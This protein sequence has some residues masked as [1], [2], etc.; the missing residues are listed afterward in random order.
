MAKGLENMGDLGPSDLMRRGISAIEGMEPSIRQQL[1]LDELQKLGPQS[2]A[3]GLVL[4][5]VTAVLKEDKV[6]PQKD[7]SRG[8]W[9]LYNLLSLPT[10]RPLSKQWARGKEAVVNFSGSGTKEK[11]VKLGYALVGLNDLPREVDKATV[12][13]DDLVAR[14][15][16]QHYSMSGKG[17][18]ERCD[19]GGLA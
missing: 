12:S 17:D 4:S 16:Q 18:Y 1:G 19:D 11:L 7:D 3:L 6:A 9:K 10:S 15:R 5:K 2:E 14:G 8:G 13:L